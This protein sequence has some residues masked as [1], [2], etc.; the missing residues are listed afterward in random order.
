MFLE[1]IHREIKWIDT[2]HLLE[3]KKG[4]KVLFI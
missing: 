2:K 3:E 4:E 1:D